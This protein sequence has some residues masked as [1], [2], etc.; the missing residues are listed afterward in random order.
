MAT[1]KTEKELRED[2]TK[3]G[4]GEVIYEMGGLWN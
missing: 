3:M 1:L 4:V 2:N